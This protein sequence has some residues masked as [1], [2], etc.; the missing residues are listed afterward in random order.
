MKFFLG[1]ST[2][3]AVASLFMLNQLTN[4]DVISPKKRSKLIRWCIARQSSNG[5]FHGRPNKP[6]DSCYS[7]W[8]GATLQVENQKWTQKIN[9]CL[10]ELRIIII[11]LQILNVLHFV[12]VEKIKEFTLST[13]DEVIGGFGKYPDSLPDAL[14][15]YLS[16]AGMSVM[17]FYSLQTLNPALNITERAHNRLLKNNFVDQETTTNSHVVDDINIPD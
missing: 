16:L 2:F 6:D 4:P 5:G 13:Q 9:L 1:G 15:T 17:G 7:F 8:I 11:I 3:C 10:F 14:H 12:D